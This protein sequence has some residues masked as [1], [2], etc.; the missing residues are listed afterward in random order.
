MPP[1][2]PSFDLVDDLIPPLAERGTKLISESVC[3]DA[4]G[5]QS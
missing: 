1:E 5:R 3:A 2:E 4:A